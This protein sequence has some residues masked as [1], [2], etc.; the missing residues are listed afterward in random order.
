MAAPIGYNRVYAQ[1][2]G[3]FSTGGLLRAMKAGRSFAT[4]GPMVFFTVDGQGPGATLQLDAPRKLTVR[5]E[6]LSAG[7]LDRIEIVRNGEVVTYEAIGGSHSRYAISAEVDMPR[8]GWMA[9]RV[10]ERPGASP[11]FAQTSPVYVSVAGKPGETAG[12]ARHF[13]RWLERE[14]VFYQAEQR[15]RSAAEKDA[16]LPFLRDGFKVYCKLPRAS[17]KV[18]FA[19]TSPVYVSVAGKPPNRRIGTLLYPL[20]GTGDRLLSGRTA[21]P[22][23][24][25]ERSDAP[26]PARRPGGLPQAGRSFELSQIR[27]DQHCLCEGGR[28]AGQTAGSARY[29]IRWLER[30]IVFYQAEQRFRSAAEKEA[31]FRFLRDGLKVYRKLPRASNKV[32]LC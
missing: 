14:I 10:F 20:A 8:S 11:K 15:F 21:L 29:F 25:G 9:A 12:S 24:G 19:Q 18:E 30:E 13:I 7:S 2:R 1:L 4:N 27:A 5:V 16:M 31:M 28:Q 3:A 22:Q 23:C 17:N 26:L 32:E 6:T